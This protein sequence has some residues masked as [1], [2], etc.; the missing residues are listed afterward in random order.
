MVSPGP[1]PKLNH[2]RKLF[3]SIL[4]WVGVGNKHFF[5]KFFKKIFFQTGS[6]SVTQARMLW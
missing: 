4:V 5:K 2:W 6:R 1:D 3:Q